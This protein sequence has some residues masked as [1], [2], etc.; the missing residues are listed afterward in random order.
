LFFRIGFFSDER[1][2]CGNVL[3]RAKGKDIGLLS[4]QI[5]NTKRSYQKKSSSIEQ[6]SY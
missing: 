5:K 1:E 2:E 6:S 4:S 3:I